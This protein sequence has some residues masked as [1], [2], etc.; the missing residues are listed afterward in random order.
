M[1]PDDNVKPWHISM[2]ISQ[3]TPQE[4]PPELT[5]DVWDLIEE[6]AAEAPD[7][8]ATEIRECL[9]QGACSEKIEQGHDLIS[10]P[11]VLFVL[12]EQSDPNAASRPDLHGL[13]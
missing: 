1:V 13:S 11:V 6:C 3:L 5:D 10:L 9:T 4:R 12:A 8:D 2:P 7:F